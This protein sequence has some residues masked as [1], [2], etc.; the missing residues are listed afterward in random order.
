VGG[1]PESSL[2]GRILDDRYELLE[3]I[4]A[5]GVGEV[6]RARLLKLDRLVAVKV[7][8]ENLVTNADFVERFQ[9][10]ARAIS[11]MHH[12]HCV[13]VLD[14]GLLESRPYLVLEYLPGDTVTRLLQGGPFAPP[15]AINIALQLLDALSYFHDQNVIHRDLKS[16]NVMLV[17]SGGIR[18]F[19]KVLDFGMAK[20]LDS[21]GGDS[22]QLSQ[23]GLVAGTVSAMAPEQLQQLR[24]DHRIDLYATGILLYEMIVGRRPFRASDPAVVARMQLESAPI[25]PRVILGDAGLSSELE[26]VIMRA[27]EKNRSNRFDSA[28]KMAQAIQRTPEG[29]A[30]PVASM[31]LPPSDPTPTVADA[32]PPTASTEEPPPPLSVSAPDA[33]EAPAPAPSP[34]PQTRRRRA[35]VGVA[36]AAG[37]LAL[38]VAWAGR[39]ALPGLRPRPASPAG[40]AASAAHVPAPAPAPAPAVAA[41]PEPAPSSEGAPP[42][43]ASASPGG[44]V[45]WIAHRDL[46]VVHA[47]RGD[48][49]E[50][51][52]EVKAALDEDAA[53]AAGDPALLDAAVT[54]LAPHR[55]PFVLEAFR[56]NPRLADTLVE[57]IATGKTRLQRHAALKA[58]GRLHKSDSADLIAMRILDVEQATTCGEMRT[59]FKKL[60]TSRDPRAKE[61]VEDLRGRDSS[62][63]QARCLRALL[64]R[65]RGKPRI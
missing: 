23:A 17:A 12:P 55:V 47:G 53:A 27:L 52:R 62:D 25:R 4:G 29:Q 37:S 49:N 46:A 3:P 22:S 21:E 28:E 8:H 45:P 30:T 34:P 38:I 43:A 63:R 36:V 51:F 54:V 16:E 60:G 14:F 57:A 1:I 50:A 56:S 9:R 7:L 20:I 19:V 11:R 18:D 42:P 10:E 40:P 31:R 13:A 6:Y 26:S 64:E 15:R 59:A 35:M 61:L 32:E 65:R 39:S 24:P 48:E 41:A 33:E 58:L 44:T 2:S 5:G